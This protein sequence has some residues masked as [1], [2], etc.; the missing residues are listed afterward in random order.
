MAGVEHLHI[1]AMVANDGGKRLNAERRESHDPDIPVG[2]GTIGFFLR[3]RIIEIFV[4]NVNKKN[5]HADFLFVA[6][7]GE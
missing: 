4:S 3:E 1:M 5:L 7:S 6:V 2:M